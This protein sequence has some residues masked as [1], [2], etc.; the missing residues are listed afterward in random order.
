EEVEEVF[1][2]LAVEDVFSPLAVEEVSSLSRQ[3]REN[4]DLAEERNL[5]AAAMPMIHCHPHHPKMAA[6]PA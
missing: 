1:S 5:L 6:H 4:E 3:E 2:P